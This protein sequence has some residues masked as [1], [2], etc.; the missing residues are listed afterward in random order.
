M[1]SSEEW[2]FDCEVRFIA[3]MPLKQRR[4]YLVLVME[5]RGLA[6]RQALEAALLQMWKEKK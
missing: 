2:R 4:E 5:K 3:N 6:S 1:N